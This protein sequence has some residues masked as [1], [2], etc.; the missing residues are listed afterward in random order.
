MACTCGLHS[1]FRYAAFQRA[2]VF[3]TDS[4]FCKGAATG[5]TMNA[6]QTEAMTRFEV[7]HGR[8]AG[9]VHGISDKADAQAAQRVYR[10]A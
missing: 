5:K 9:T 1:P 3:A 4:A 7:K 2:S 6:I 8:S 10:R